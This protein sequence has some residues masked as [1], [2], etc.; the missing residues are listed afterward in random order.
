MLTLAISS[1]FSACV[2]CIKINGKFK[3]AMRFESN[4]N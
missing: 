1:A 3:I 4:E 2:R